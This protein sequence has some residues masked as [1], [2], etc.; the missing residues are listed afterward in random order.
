MVRDLNLDGRHV[1]YLRS[2]EQNHHAAKKG[3]ADAKLS[4]L[5][6]DIQVDIGLGGNRNSHLCEPVQSNDAVR[7]SYANEFYLKR[8]GS[9]WI[10]NDLSLGG[11]RVTGMANPQ[12]DQD[13]VNKRALDDMKQA[14]ELYFEKHFV[15]AVSQLRVP[16]SFNEQKILTLGDPKNNDHAVNLRTLQTEISQNNTMEL[17][18]YLSLDGSSEPTND[19]TM[20]YN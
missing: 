11:H 17:P 5:S 19:L 18:K 4:L 2:P 16:V 1:S 15:S 3:Y 6:G 20:S 10:R 7:L 8:D 9:N 13:A 12:L 14:Q